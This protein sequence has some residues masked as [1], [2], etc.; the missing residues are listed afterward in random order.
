[1][2][3][4]QGAL[5]MLVQ[6][7]RAVLKKCR[8]LNVF[9]ALLLGASLLGGTALAA[10]PVTIDNTQE[11]AD[12][13]KKEYTTIDVNSGGTLNI[14]RQGKVTGTAVTVKAGGALNSAKD[15]HIGTPEA[16]GSKTGL[17]AKEKLVIDGGKVTG[18]HLGFLSAGAELEV[19]NG[20]SLTGLE[21]L[22]LEQGKIT[23]GGGT[24]GRLEVKDLQIAYGSLADDAAANGK[25]F[26]DTDGQLVVRN[27]LSL[28]G[29][30]ITN[31]LTKGS[32]SAGKLAL[33]AATNT[34]THN[35]DDAKLT[36]TGGTGDGTFFNGSTF[37][38]SKGQVF[39]R[40]NGESSSASRETAAAVDVNGTGKLNVDKGRWTIGSLAQADN[41]LVTVGSSSGSAKLKVAGAV[42][43]VEADGSKGITVA[44][45]GALK[46]KFANVVNADNT[47]LKGGV[48]KVLVESGGMLQF[49]DGK[50]LTL[51][52]LTTLRGNLL[53][54]AS[55]GLIAGVAVS[56]VAGKTLQQLAGASVAV[57][58]NAVKSNGA[59]INNSVGVSGITGVGTTVGSGARLTLSGQTSDFS[60]V[61][62]TLDTAS[63]Q[64][65][66]DSSEGKKLAGGIT[67]QGSG[68]NTLDVLGNNHTINGG[69]KTAGTS[70]NVITVQGGSHTISG[71]VDASTATGTTINVHNGA[72]LAVN[73]GVKGAGHTKINVGD[74]NS[75]GT[76]V[77][78]GIQMNGGRIDFDPPFVAA[79]DTS[80]AS[81]GGLTFASST[82]DGLMNVGQNSM[83][84]LGSTDAGWLR[85]E[86]ANYQSLG[87]GLWGKDV[88]AALALR[89]PQTLDAAGGIN[90]DGT[91]VS[92]GAAATANTAKF[93][94]K[95]LLVVDAAGVGDKVA[96][97]G[98]G[99]A[100][101]LNVNGG[102]KL[103]IVG[104]KGGSTVHI[105]DKFNGGAATAPTSWTG[106]NLTTSTALLSATGGTF[107]AADGKYSVTL[108][109]NAA[110]D[111]FPKM[112][113]EMSG[114]VGD[115]VTQ[116]GIDPASDNA[117]VRLV[118]R[119]VSD[120]YIGRQDR[121][122]A[123]A[124]IEGAAQIAPV[125]AVQASTMNV[126][127]VASGAALN[128][129]SL[130]LPRTD[131]HRTV[132]LHQ[133]ADGVSLSG[134][135]AG[136]GMK[137]GLGLWLMPLY[138]TSHVWGME[139]G[140]F[141]GGYHSSLGGIALGADYTVNDMFRFGAAFNIGAGYA[142]SSGDFNGTDNRFNFWGV[143]LYG[144]WVYNNFGLTADVGYTSNYCPP[145]C[146]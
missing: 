95:S 70:T 144:G 134:M 96:L 145:P 142:K 1:M 30:N 53:T 46:V 18:A 127:N 80:N 9:G 52:D 61:A 10:D 66:M 48:N 56:D 98:D 133:D 40:D 78:S 88:T 37:A 122:K 129:T 128:R 42:K 28:T 86:V 39:L 131:S 83:V 22:Q 100:S 90:V 47:T 91:W 101:A 82:V 57:M 138:Q 102:A 29:G 137:N 38:V 92:G 136:D 23:L 3:L 85:N 116:T 140:D 4:T 24:G 55:K 50:T 72:T 45:G 5:G 115:V 73:G 21:K 93:A 141:E 76:L 106:K 17:L 62:L 15:L 94:D 16:D 103:H 11:V 123:A 7:Y 67:M 75:K 121:D 81:L 130:A 146:S 104:G 108:K 97:T 113:G 63:L 41:S 107:G 84:S 6:R 65:G 126:A 58:E 19:K 2:Q 120:N 26:L 33:D 34:Y 32:L 74:A 87:H 14:A 118:S 60:T 20:G 27:K 13:V 59:P 79:G 64:L 36:L 99:A 44:N 12:G 139:S 114:L 31:A 77:A 69:I 119:A 105:T 35:H 51:A 71:K 125:G 110:S 8:L 25:I 89:A 111:M 54:G 68:V 112:S 143:S 49:L 135:S 109:A 117:G 124:T 132:A 43:N